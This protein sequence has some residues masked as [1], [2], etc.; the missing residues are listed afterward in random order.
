MSAGRP[1]T[2]LKALKDE[3]ADCPT[4]NRA[5][6]DA[7]EIYMLG[8]GDHMFHLDD[9]DEPIVDPTL[10][11]LA[12]AFLLR[13]AAE[14]ASGGNEAD[15]CLPVLCAATISAGEPLLSLGLNFVHW[16]SRHGSSQGLS[17]ALCTLTRLMFHA[18]LCSSLADEIGRSL[19]KDDPDSVRVWGCEDDPSG[20]RNLWRGVWN[21]AT[22]TNHRLC[23]ALAEIE[24]ELRIAE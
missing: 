2:I 14:E 1:E 12:C 10:L 18:H 22:G 4:L 24:S 20:Q 15:Y 21:L 23:R 8:H 5:E 6:L 19:D 13:S 16:L 17:L 9:V 11:L 7:C 3:S